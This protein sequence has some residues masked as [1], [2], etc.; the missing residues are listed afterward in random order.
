MSIPPAPL[1]V[2]DKAA[3]IASAKGGIGDGF[4]QKFM[5]ELADDLNISAALA[6]VYEVVGVVNEKM[7]A[8]SLTADEKQAAIEFFDLAGEVLGISFDEIEKSAE[9]MPANVKVLVDERQIARQEKHFSESDRLRDE[10]KA[11]GYEVEDTPIGPVVKR[12]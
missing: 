4:A 12:I 11:L 5:A 6:V 2:S 10:I 9:N 8:K 7:T 1:E 3:R